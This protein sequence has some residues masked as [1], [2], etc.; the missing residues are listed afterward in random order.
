MKI[1]KGDQIK[2]IS[3]NDKGKQGK[4]LAVFPDESRIVA[5]GLNMK[6][7]HVRPK[8]QGK[9]GE[10]VRIAMPFSVSIA[11]LVCSKCG[12]PSRA[13]FRVEQNKKYRICVRCKSEI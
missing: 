5:E 3:G 1:R 9:K 4:V 10:L 7:K 2:I 12:K 6:K 8:Q 11:M 13:G